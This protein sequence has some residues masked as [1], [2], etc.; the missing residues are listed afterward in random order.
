MLQV[1][2]TQRLLCV[3]PRALLPTLQH[4]SPHVLSGSSS[5]MQLRVIAPGK[6]LG[7]GR[8]D[9]SWFQVSD[10]ETEVPEEEKVGAT[11]EGTVSNNMP[12]LCP[13]CLLVFPEAQLLL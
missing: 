5:W 7:Q 8:I 12:A 6:C 4:Q 1:G 2:L 13:T 10:L 3:C 9:K 11:V